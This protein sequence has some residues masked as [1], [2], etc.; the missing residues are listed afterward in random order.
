MTFPLVVV[1]ALIQAHSNKKSFLFSFLSVWLR[2]HSQ[3]FNADTHYVQLDEHAWHTSFL[4]VN[5]QLLHYNLVGCMK[6][7]SGQKKRRGKVKIDKYAATEKEREKHA[8]TLLLN[9]NSHKYINKCQKPLQI[10]F[11]CWDL[12][13]FFR[14]LFLVSFWNFSISVCHRLIMFPFCSFSPPKHWISV[15][16]CC[17]TKS[18]NGRKW[19]S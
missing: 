3:Q 13:R 10:S 15:L 19:Y 1:E 9:E 14:F 7:F 17:G 4:L 8:S 16:V 12:C 5:H 6:F 18:E 11:S 2:L